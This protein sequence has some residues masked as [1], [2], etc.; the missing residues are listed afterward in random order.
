MKS[1]T[2]N[3]C[4][5]KLTLSIGIYDDPDNQKDGEFSLY[6]YM[7]EKGGI[8]SD[9]EVFVKDE[10]NGGYL[11]VNFDIKTKD[12]G[13]SHLKYYGTADGDR[14]MWKTEGFIEDV[15]VNGNPIELEEGD[16][17]IVDL[18]LSVKDKYKGAI[19]N[20]N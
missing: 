7:I 16:I 12:E 17:A 20:I 14:N 13:R 4:I 19:F 1:I 15:E 2:C 6:E 10:G 3:I 9:D 5:T 11:I 8:R 18:G